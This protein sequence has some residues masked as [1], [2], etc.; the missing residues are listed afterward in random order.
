VSKSPTEP[1]R[2]P[3]RIWGGEIITGQH[4]GTW[5]ASTDIVDD[6]VNA[7]NIEWLSM[8]EHTEILSLAVAEAFEE[9]IDLAC[10]YGHPESVQA[11]LAK[12]QSAREKPPAKGGEE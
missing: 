9:A 4:K 12:A 8:K 6:S 11:M 7:E 3:P 1:G 2:F 10:K 5:I